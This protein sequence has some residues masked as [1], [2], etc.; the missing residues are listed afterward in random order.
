MTVALNTSIRTVTCHLQSG[1]CWHRR[2]SG[3][4]DTHRHT[5]TH[6]LLPVYSQGIWQ[7]L[8]LAGCFLLQPEI[9][10]SEVFCHLKFHFTLQSRSRAILFLE[11]GRK[12][13]AAMVQQPGTRAVHTCMTH[14]QGDISMRAHTHIHTHSQQS[15]PALSISGLTIGSLCWAGWDVRMNQCESSWLDMPIHLPK[16]RER[17]GERGTLKE[18][19]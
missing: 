14:G 7:R 19:S 4:W 1:V 11:P 6:L 10:F 8:L 15:T 2:V 16:K 9:F 13:P 12:Q 18:M 3:R 17:K 5:D